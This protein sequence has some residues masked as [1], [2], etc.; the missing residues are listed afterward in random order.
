M[1]TT[2]PR[3]Q[4][5]IYG[6][7]RKTFGMGSDSASCSPKE[8]SWF[9]DSDFEVRS[10]SFGDDHGCVVA[11]G[12]KQVN[13]GSEEGILLAWGSNLDGS[14]LDHYICIDFALGQLGRGAMNTNRID[15]PG[16]VESLDLFNV[17]AV[18]CGS[19]FTLVLTSSGNV[20]SFGSNDCWCLGHT[21]DLAKV[22]RP[23]KILFN[24]I[25]GIRESHSQKIVMMS[26]GARHSLLLSED[27]CVWGF[28]DN[29][30][31]QL[32]L[33][34]GVSCTK[35]AV[36]LKALFGIPIRKI[37]CGGSFSLALTVSGK[38]YAWG[39]NE[40][41]QLGLDT[42]GPVHTPTLIKHL[43]AITDISAGNA[44][45]AALN[46][47]GTCFV[48]GD[49]SKGQLATTAVRTAAPL[50]LKAMDGCDFG[51]VSRV[52]CGN[53]ST[54]IIAKRR[55]KNSPCIK[56][57]SFG[58]NEFGEL[59]IGD[60]CSRSSPSQILF[61]EVLTVDQ[62]CNLFCGR[63][64]QIFL[65]SDSVSTK[66]SLFVNEGLTLREVNELVLSIESEGSDLSGAQLL[67]RI[68][69]C[70][71]SIS[72]LSG[73]FLSEDHMT[74]EERVEPGLSFPEL[75]QAYDRLLSVKHTKWAPQ[76]RKSLAESCSVVM[77]PD[78]SLVNRTFESLRG[79]LVLFQNPFLAQDEE[80]IS[81]I[82][83]LTEFVNSLSYA[84][85]GIFEDWWKK[86]PLILRNF[87]S[88]VELFNRALTLYTLRKWEQ[89]TMAGLKALKWLWI[90]NNKPFSDDDPLKFLHSESTFTSCSESR[91]VQPIDPL[92]HIESATSFPSLFAFQARAN[93][94]NMIDV[95]DGIPGSD[96][97]TSGIAN[98]A[99]AVFAR[100]MEH[101]LKN[102]VIISL[103]DRPSPNPLIPHSVFI[104]E[105][106]S[107]KI[108]YR[109]DFL[110]F[111]AST[112]PGFFGHRRFPPD[113]DVFCF[114]K[115]PF[116]MTLSARTILLALDAQRQ[117]M[118]T[119]TFSLIRHMNSY[120]GRTNDPLPVPPEPQ[121]IFNLIPL[122][123]DRL[124]HDA[125]HAVEQMTPA[126]L[127][128]PLRVKFSNEMG[129]DGGG[130]S[131]EFMDIFF[132]KLF[133][134][135]DMFE[136]T[137]PGTGMIWFNP[138]STRPASAFRTAGR[139]LGIALF[140]GCL[141]SAAAAFPPVLFRRL[142]GWPATLQDL[143]SM[144]PT[145][146]K[147]LT[148]MLSHE[149]PNTFEETFYGFEF[150]VTVRNR[151]ADDL[152]PNVEP[153]KT[154][155]LP[156][157]F[158][159]Q[160]VIFDNREAYVRAMVQWYTG[161]SVEEQLKQFRI[162]FL[163]SCG[164][165]VGPVL[166]QLL[167]EQLEVILKGK[168]SGDANFFDLQSAALYKDPYHKDH[169]VIKRFW[170]VFHALP[171]EL[172]RKFL[173]FMTGTDA[174]PA[175]KGLK[176]IQILI[177]ASGLGPES[178][179]VGPDQH[180]ASPTDVNQT[181]QNRREQE[182]RQT[183]EGSSESQPELQQS[184]RGTILGLPRL[185]TLFSSSGP[186]N[187]NSSGS[188]TA[189]SGN[190]RF[191]FASFFSLFGSHSQNPASVGSAVESQSDRGDGEL[192]DF[193]S[194]DFHEIGHSE[195][196]LDALLG[197]LDDLSGNDGQSDDEDWADFAQERVFPQELPRQ[198]DRIGEPDMEHS[199]GT[200]RGR[201]D[202]DEDA[203]DDWGYEDVQ[204]KQPVADSAAGRPNK[205][206]RVGSS[207]NDGSDLSD[208]DKWKAQIVLDMSLNEPGSE[209]STDV[210]RLPVA[211]TCTLVLD[212]PPYRTVEMLMDRL[213]YAV[214][215]AG[216]FHLV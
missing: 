7:G 45:S 175:V 190:R 24:S 139:V 73:N 132:R 137:E 181:V 97:T 115:F 12:T 215:N 211:H 25:P 96:S 66:S 193:E 50:K 49:G 104:N 206:I 131:R 126:D 133:K 155:G 48:W 19:R 196:M 88:T 15:A 194:E 53:D 94:S 105:V 205:K 81:G 166:D 127:K 158:S 162:G 134:Y 61:E 101:S 153:Y 93:A 56:V 146:A 36:L 125:F 80:N 79:L 186:M 16:R 60:E 208:D 121:T 37:V 189:N 163:E 143:A 120:G 103:G 185:S 122:R 154:V 70:F 184:N 5:R 68:Q 180:S 114:C 20:L 85:K 150:S 91:E 63:S 112:R 71:S 203:E 74:S 210:K 130:V 54:F 58:S 204:R 165:S 116:M 14:F 123:R 174:I 141:T 140:N 21:F 201:N 216:E 160:P 152:R 84:E 149:N 31:S 32:G 129:V 138:L 145:V 77:S 108:D 39:S 192:S 42:K 67:S 148:A 55:H 87:R 157:A 18:S 72:R 89:P 207:Q 170:S 28:G 33:G 100:Y 179:R 164:V 13:R 183:Q 95:I 38:I 135:G 65:V 128:K 169:P 51:C 29:S 34:S 171:L 151:R 69:Q 57:Y 177:Q 64:Q 9:G 8:I 182:D 26:S 198:G 46:E 176:E 47:E 3:A 124:L 99:S 156:C 40:Y 30:S 23:K 195:R 144:H 62:S 178:S 212:L 172:K 147:W 167:P 92:L 200:K 27:G 107:K 202:E 98:A 199:H 75:Q 110:Q 17:I 86:N 188:D 187:A 197:P 111:Y 83:R 4:Q 117:Q 10:A 159:K 11:F 76:I 109:N 52:I 59:G 161:G 173:K 209:L 2:L 136:D 106:L 90:V 142:L 78:F 22:S 168:G 191:P 43:S 214:E 118:E 41:G 213:V 82:R 44:H 113:V 119:Q 35:G 1:A 6:W 102:G